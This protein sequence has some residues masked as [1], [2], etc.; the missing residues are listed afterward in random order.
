M[1]E[2]LRPCTGTEPEEGR[3]DARTVGCR[4]RRR[5][6]VLEDFVFDAL[7]RFGVP[8]PVAAAPRRRRRA[9][10]AGSISAIRDLCVALEAKGFEY[11][12][13]R[14]RF[15]DDALRGNELLLAG[16]RVLDVHH[17]VHGS[18]RS[19]R[20]S[21]RRSGSRPPR[22]RSAHS[23][24]RNGSAYAECLNASGAVGPAALQTR[25]DGHHPGC[26]AHPGK[27]ARIG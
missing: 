11:H 27:I 9:G 16:C 2:R 3:G 12:G 14:A 15:D 18:G 23:R 17:R 5:E 22:P 1:A 25:T 24:S 4:D 26:A 8:L 10:S 13:L 7:R 20:R 19:R 6:S 21:P